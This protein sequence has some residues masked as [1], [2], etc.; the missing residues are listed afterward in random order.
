MHGNLPRTVYCTNCSDI[1]CQE[2]FLFGHCVGHAAQR[3][4]ET[5][6]AVSKDLAVTLRVLKVLWV[7]VHRCTAVIQLAAQS[8]W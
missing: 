7:V 3:L 4:P 1:R 2:C 6:P 8:R 5:L